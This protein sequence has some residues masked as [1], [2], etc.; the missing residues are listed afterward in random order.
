MMQPKSQAQ[1]EVV[2]DKDMDPAS[3]QQKVTAGHAK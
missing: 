1:N 3:Q 2:S